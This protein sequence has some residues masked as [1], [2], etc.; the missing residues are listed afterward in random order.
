MK[1]LAGTVAVAA[2]FYSHFNGRE[3]P[4]N[5][6]LVMACVAVYAVCVTLISLVSYMHEGDAFFSAYLSNV[7]EL[8]TGKEDVA[9][10]Q[11]V[12]VQST[13]GEKGKSTYTLTMRRSV[14]KNAD[15]SVLLKKPYEEYYC[16]DGQ[17]AVDA[18]R[19]DLSRLVGKLGRLGSA[20]KSK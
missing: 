15:L 6:D 13:I 17:V 7:A 11:K 2:S 14:R 10:A 4:D 12:W 3:F 9:L 18:L 8:M 20:D 16:E 5:R 1:I 19:K